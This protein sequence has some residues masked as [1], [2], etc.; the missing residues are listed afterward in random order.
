MARL[1][2]V[3]Q[4]AALVV[5]TVYPAAVEA[6]IVVRLPGESRPTRIPVRLPRWLPLGGPR[7]RD[8][9]PEIGR[10]VRDYYPEAEWVG[11]FLTLPNG[12][13]PWFPIPPATAPLTP[14]AAAAPAS[15]S[16]RLGS[17]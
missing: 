11:L 1:K 15:S 2:D 13:E 9:L 16:A 5:A 14:S 7:A 12:D 10:I 8:T 4:L 3:A 17:P 6:R